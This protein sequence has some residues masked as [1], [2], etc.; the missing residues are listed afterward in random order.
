MV[1]GSPLDVRGALCQPSPHCCGAR[2]RLNGRGSAQVGRVV[3]QSA[4]CLLMGMTEMVLQ[5]SHEVPKLL[6]SL[7]HTC[8]CSQWSVPTTLTCTRARAFERSRPVDA[9]GGSGSTLPVDGDDCNGVGDV[10]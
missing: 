10:E 3:T 6:R 8:N 7:C 4:P 5:I 1:N 9:G 2:A